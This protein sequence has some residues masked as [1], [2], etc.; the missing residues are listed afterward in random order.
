MC[1]DSFVRP[2]R[3]AAS[4]RDAESFGD[5]LKQAVQRQLPSRSRHKNTTTASSNTAAASDDESFAQ[6][7]ARITKA[8]AKLQR[9]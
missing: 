5:K 8:K 6:M 4:I 9:A 7:L 2:S 3:C 1:Q